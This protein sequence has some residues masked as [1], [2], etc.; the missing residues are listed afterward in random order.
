M[1]A[2]RTFLVAFWLILIVYTLMVIGT[3]GL[4][5]FHAFFGDMAAMA[6]SG[7]FNLDFM[8]FLLLSGI[9]VAWRNR[10]SVTGL[11]LALLAVFGGITVLMPYLLYLSYAARGDMR[12]V[13]LGT[14]RMA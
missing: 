3:H 5:L 4:N 9:W 2:F 10:F 12:E 1:L 8:G 6:W 14:E 13:L 11:L 7:Q